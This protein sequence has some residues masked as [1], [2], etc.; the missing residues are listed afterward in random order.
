[1]WKPPKGKGFGIS[2]RDDDVDEELDDELLVPTPEFSIVDPGQELAVSLHVDRGWLAGCT[3]LLRDR[4]QLIFYGPPGTGKKYIAKDVCSASCRPG[5]PSPSRVFH[6][7]YSYEDFFEGVRPTPRS[8]G[9]VGFELK[10]GSV[11][12]LTDRA[13]K[14]PDQFVRAGRR[15]DQSREPRQDFR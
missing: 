7:A 14:R 4:P 3:D 8:D 2:A 5:R 6:P 1:M 13:G 10:P 15:R 9:Q 11:R 12:C